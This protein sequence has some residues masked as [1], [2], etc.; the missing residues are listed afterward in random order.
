[1]SQTTLARTASIARTYRW[2]LRRGDALEA[3][4]YFSVA[5]VLALFLAD[6]GATYFTKITDLATGL[7]IVAGL[8]GTDLLLI[9]LLLAARIPLVDRTFGHDKVMALHG[10]LGK[11]V[12]YL[13]LA[14]MA[15]LLIG[16]GIS[17][18]LNPVAEAFSM[19][20]NLPDML[21]A[22]IATGLM[23]LVVVTSLVIVRRR[24][25]YQF[26]YA[27]HLLSYAAVLAAL[28]HQFSNG[29]LFADGTLARKYWLVLSVGTFAAIVIFR[30]ILPTALTLKH[31]LV[32]SSVDI[33]APGVVTIT[34]TGRKL[35]RLP[36]R[37]GQFFNW[38]FW[39]PGLWWDSHPY[40]L[41]AGPDGR[42]LRITVRDLGDSSHKLLTLPVG[43]SVSFEGPYG[44]FTEPSRTS[45]KAVFIGAGIGITPIRALLEDS[46]LTKGEGQ[47][48]LRGSI[49]EQVYLW[50]E[51]YDLCVQKGA[52]LRVL[53]GH[54]PADANT[55]LSA[56]AYHA[57]ES[58][59][60]L[61]PTIRE[62]D[63][64]ICGPAVWSDLVARDARLAGVP[65]NRIHLERFDF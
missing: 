50:Q 27:V 59:L 29:M 55:W 36:A 45:P 63:V 64:Y 2:R 22:F 9:M 6:G 37:G 38:R 7:G 53:V 5:I 51:T 19:I 33:L 35:N 48:I 34:M 58:L 13:I 8:V 17:E 49:P 3:L 40:S 57:G 65:E 61:A 54:R 32:V 47:V 30:V 1:M 42:T 14:H 24:L 44:L 31:R 52:G 20:A 16:Y 4:V 23:I 60:T 21:L 43:T 18:G 28:P 10:K 46:P 26:W 15:L 62:A 11:P 25:R 39:A 41:S 56:E 12:L